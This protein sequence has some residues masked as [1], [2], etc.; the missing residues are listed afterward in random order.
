M[1]SRTSVEKFITLTNTGDEFINRVQANV[2]RVLDGISQLP[3]LNGV[4]VENVELLS[5]SVN[6]VIHSLG[7]APK[8]FI[9]VRSYYA[10]DLA[11]DATPVEDTTQAVDRTLMI[12]LRVDRD[13]NVNLWVY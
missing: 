5:A 7:R 11:G 4:L 8:G 13:V 2:K 1:P 6:N 3:F 12:S 9:V 10:G